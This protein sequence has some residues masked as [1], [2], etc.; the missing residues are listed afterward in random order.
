MAVDLFAVYRMATS[1]G[2]GSGFLKA[3]VDTNKQAIRSPPERNWET[4]FPNKNS[5]VHP[6]TVIVNYAG[7]FAVNCVSIT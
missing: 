7:D 3:L 1:G 6:T 5:G 4:E 2:R